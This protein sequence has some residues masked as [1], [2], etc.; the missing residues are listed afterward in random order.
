[1]SKDFYYSVYEVI[2]KI[3]FG[4]VTTYGYIAK[5][6]GLASSARLVGT[7]CR[8]RAYLLDLPFHRVLNR[9]GELTGKHSFPTP[10]FMKNALEAEGIEVIG[11]KVDL[12][13]FLWIP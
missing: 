11:D 5:S 6:L 9:N 2:A 7:A 1:L 3:P 4:K 13:K 8:H 12:S 10:D